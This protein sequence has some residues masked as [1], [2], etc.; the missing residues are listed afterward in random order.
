VHLDELGEALRAV[1]DCADLAFLPVA[2]DT[3]GEHFDLFV[4]PGPTGAVTEGAAFAAAARVDARPRRVF[5]VDSLERTAT[6]KL[7]HTQEPT[8]EHM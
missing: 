5:I 7:R 6:G 3:T 8:R 4:V 2:D 1:L